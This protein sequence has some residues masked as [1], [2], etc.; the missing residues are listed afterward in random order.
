VDDVNEE[1]LTPETRVGQTL[2]GK[3]KL[4]RL[5]GEGGMAVVYAATHRN[6]AT[7]AIK[8][9]NP[10]Y[11]RRADI[12]TRFLRE[13]YIANKAGKG[14][15]QVL[16]D[17]VSDDG[18]PYLVMELLR[19][20]AVDL[21]AQRMGG[22][23]V[24]RDVLWIAKQTLATLAEAHAVGIVHRDLKPEN[25]FW[26]TGD[27]IKILDFGIARLR[28]AKTTETTRT[29]MIL[30]TLGF[31]SPEQAVGA[32]ADID[33]RTDIFSVVA[34]P[35]HLLTGRE[36]H[37]GVTGNP[38]VVAATKAAP[39]IAGV[40]PSVPRDV[41]RAVDRALAVKRENR[42]PSAR[43]MLQDVERVAQPD[44]PTEPV[45]ESV[46]IPR[47]RIPR[48]EVPAPTATD[49]EEQ[50][51]A[52]M[53]Y[54]RAMSDADA[55]SLR[56]VF[57]AIEAA[58][59][60]RTEHGQAHPQTIRK[61]DVAYRRAAAALSD[62]HIGLFCNVRPTGFFARGEDFLWQPRPPLSASAGQ[63]HEDGVRMLGLLPG[64][65]KPEFEAVAGML[66]GDKGSF[67]DYATLLQ[68]S[69]FAH[70]VFRIEPRADDPIVEESDS[71]ITAGTPLPA[72]VILASLSATTDAAVRASLLP[73]LERRAEGHEAEIGEKLVTAGVDLAMG[74]LRMLGD[75]R[76][77]AAQAALERALRS[78][79]PIVRVEAMTKLGMEGERL[80]AELSRALETDPSEARVATLAEVEKYKVKA[81][82]PL[83]ALRAR[84]GGFDA[85]PI[86]ERRGVLH[87]LAALLPSRAE[88]I[89][90][91]LL[92][93]QRLLA[94]EAH[95]VTREI[96]ADLLGK[97]GTSPEARAALQDAAKARW[98]QRGGRVR[99]VAT[100]ALAGIEKRRASGETA[101]VR[102]PASK[103]PGKRP[104]R[105]PS[106]PPSK[107]P[108][109][110]ARATKRPGPTT[111]RPPSP[112]RRPPRPTS[113]P[114]RK[115]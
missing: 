8:I 108:A 42:Y 60:S 78:P 96:A 94:A 87:A 1:R 38:L 37:E 115:R 102:P 71:S 52:S 4:D 28:D 45:V 68:S 73:R 7:A 93:S 86:K 58:L 95:E 83:L 105:R 111:K 59:T 21:R 30:G 77:P 104:S 35:F 41:A 50:E 5:I 76:T 24:L 100:E 23:L 34:I 67:G 49:F 107:H 85:L 29:G 90:I 89:A 44:E 84:S 75:L 25:L 80:R 10:E 26:T 46:R 72:G 82:G 69:G 109:A 33:A 2:G 99:D 15:V 32:T 101:Q 74:L 17:D 27:K 11:A 64:L 106:K 63:M 54:A 113:K 43:E 98:L 16:D 57:G 65:T 53:G 9:L 47:M 51:P 55:A 81:A 18:S 61:L 97:I 39:P 36:I 13:A 91:E 22:R 20:E 12:R 62:A 40:D 103:P 92:R 3:W 88:A 110:G 114:P 31:M 48:I 70:V 14:A 112:S 66:A 56:E 6:G 79:H 19:G